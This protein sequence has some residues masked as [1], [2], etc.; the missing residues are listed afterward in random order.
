MCNHALD[1]DR[2]CVHLVESLVESAIDSPLFGVKGQGMPFRKLETAKGNAAV[3]MSPSAE[4]ATWADS[5]A[6]KSWKKGTESASPDLDDN[7][8]CGKKKFQKKRRNA[9]FIYTSIQS[10]KNE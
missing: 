3:T 1:K 6:I 10:V 4:S 5:V 7:C 9:I 8:G 2:V